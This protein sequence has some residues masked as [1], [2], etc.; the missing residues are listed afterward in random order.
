MLRTVDR[1][2]LWVHRRLTTGTRELPD[3]IGIPEPI[4]KRSFLRLPARRLVI[5]VAATLITILAFVGGVEIVQDISGPS[6]T[7]VEADPAN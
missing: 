7:V 2:I 3:P 4:A 1:L 6:S 5:V